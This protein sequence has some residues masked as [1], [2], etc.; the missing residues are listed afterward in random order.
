MGFGTE[1]DEVSELSRT[2]FFEN[3]Y[4]PPLGIDPKQWNIYRTH[5]RMLFYLMINVGFIN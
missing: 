4:N 5:R 3:E 2:D 1:F